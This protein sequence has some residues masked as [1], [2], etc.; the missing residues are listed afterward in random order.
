MCR[1]TSSKKGLLTSRRCTGCPLVDWSTIQ[2]DSDDE[3]PPALTRPHRRM[4]SGDVLWCFRCGV[5]GDK[6]AKGLRKDCK[7]KPPRQ[8]HRGGMEGQL[9]KLRGGIHPKTGESLPQ[10]V[11]LDPVI[12]S[13]KAS[14]QEEQSEPPDGFYVYVP[15]VLKAAA[16]V[17]VADG[18]SSTE[19]RT[20]LRDRIRA[21][22]LAT[23]QTRGDV[24]SD[25]LS[26]QPPCSNRSGPTSSSSPDKV[27]AI[28]ANSQAQA[29]GGDLVLGGGVWNYL[30]PGEPQ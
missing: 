22:E 18:P 5:Y 7:G 16:P 4:I 8:M 3:A 21:K 13:F 29:A 28:E 17:A 1:K 23:S 6:K 11:E 10:A 30:F 25:V 20:A 24:I 2:Q 15:E 19:R 27:M 14:G 9:R 26:L 12:V